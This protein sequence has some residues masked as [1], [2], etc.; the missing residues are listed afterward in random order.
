MSKLEE[1]LQQEVA[2]EIEEILGE[3]D[4]RAAQ[5][6][7]EAKSR[8]A[9]RVAAHKKKL[10][11]ETRAATHQAQSAADLSVSFARTQAKGEVMELV[12]QQVLSA[13]EG[14]PSQPG[15][16][17]VL[18][19]LAEG[20]LKV[21]E[22]SETVVVHPDDQDKLKDWAQQQGL[23]LQTDPE[24]RLGVRIMS[25]SGRKVENTLPERLRRTWGIFGPEIT[26]MLWE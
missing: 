17:D 23:E 5:I 4:S 24:L 18:M 1:V 11:A 9:E 21:A 10:E 25:R 19:R 20:A 8:A 13:L 3:A 12:R 6:V 2:T 15:Y 26:E 7:S 14:M 22:E 16:R